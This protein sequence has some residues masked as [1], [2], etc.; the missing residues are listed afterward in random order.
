M[1]ISDKWQEYELLDC[2]DNQ[3]LERW[4]SLMLIR[5][6]PQAIWNITNPRLWQHA[7][8]IY[9]R[10][11]EG[12]GHWENQHLP[13]KW[14]VS[15][16]RLTFRL[17]PMGFKHTGLFPEQAVNWDFID[18]KVRERKGKL[19]VLNLFAYTGGASLAAAAAGGAGVPC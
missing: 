10:S 19:N 15:Y 7:D 5:P 11:K 9:L 12:G 6:D 14:Q 3:R 17:K 13:D 8:G 2:G 16:G 4:G 18:K 1:W